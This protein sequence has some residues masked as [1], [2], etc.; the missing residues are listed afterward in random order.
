MV[1]GL[2]YALQGHLADQGIARLRRRETRRCHHHSDEASNTQFQ[3][4][5]TLMQRRS[6]TV[7]RGAASRSR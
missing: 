3:H 2:D 7:D 6:T 4:V 1:D 5:I